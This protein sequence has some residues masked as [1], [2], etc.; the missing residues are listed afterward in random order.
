MISYNYDSKNDLLYI[1]EENNL[2]GKE[3]PNNKNIIIK[4]NYK[5]EVKGLIIISPSKLIDLEL[6]KNKVPDKYLDLFL[7]LR[8]IGWDKVD[9]GEIDND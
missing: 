1:R 2:T 3:Y 5:D 9:S 6:L 7:K 8:S 4:F